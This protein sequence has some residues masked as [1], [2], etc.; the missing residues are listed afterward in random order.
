[1]IRK[2][3]MVAAAAAVPMGAIAVGVSGG[4]AG[5]AT[6]IP[7]NPTTCAMNG[8]V[9]FAQ[10]GISL[11]GITTAAKTGSTTSSVGFQNCGANG[12]VSTGAGT[13]NILTKNSKCLAPFPSN[14]TALGTSAATSCE[15]GRNITDSGG[16][17]GSPGTFKSLGK[18]I[19]A[20]PLTLHENNVGFALKSKALSESEILPGGACGATEVGFL[21]QTSV[22]T[23]PKSIGI[24][25]GTLTVCLGTDNNAGPNNNFFQDLTG[26]STIPNTQIDP[27]TSTISLH[28]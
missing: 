7:V 21:I 6:P 22:K 13:L 11:V 9:T 15:K 24:A 19:K 17:L 20:L 3:L 1:M 25:G 27:A 2:L 26:G 23:S 14:P 18:A 12:S 4:V 5:A 10:P 28:A 16:A 8:T